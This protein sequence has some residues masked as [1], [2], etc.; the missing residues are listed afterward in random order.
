MV[1]LV[2]LQTVAYLAQIV[3][4]VGTLTAA[5]IAVR[6]YVNAN[7]RA[8]EARRKEQETRD[9]EL[10]TRRVGL[11][12]NMT[13][14]LSS[15]EGV[16][17]QLEIMTYEWSDYEDF[18]MKYGSQ[19]NPEASAKRFTTFNLF[20]SLGMMIRKGFVNADDLYDLLSVNSVFNWEK[21]KGV[22]V[23]GRRRYWGEDYMR[24]FEFLSSE[25]M[26][27]KLLRDPGY[28]FPDTLDE[29]VPGK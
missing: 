7:K 2:D 25:M 29:F 17:N 20:N 21:Y 18:E 16:R 6:S 11:I 8:E 10:E 23:E 24:D 1:E 5:F 27:V 19:T 28:R 3:G 22:I 26:R 14:A 13:R 15:S 12:E 9:S 4:V